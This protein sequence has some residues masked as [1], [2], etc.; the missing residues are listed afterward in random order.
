MALP[1]VRLLHTADVHLGAPEHLFGDSGARIREARRRFIREL[2]QLASREEA[3]GV[4]IAGDLF[5]APEA[6]ATEGKYVA[7]ALRALQRDGR[8]TVLTPGTH[9]RLVDLTRFEHAVVLDQS[10]FSDHKVFETPAGEVHFYGG[11]YDPLETPDDFLLPMRDPKGPGF[12]VAVLHA[13]VADEGER[14]DA[15]DLPATPK[16]L[17]ECGCHYVALGHFHSFREIAHD[18]R[19]VGAYPGTPV[20]RKFRET[21]PRCVALVELSEEAVTVRPVTLPLPWAASQTLDVT[22]LQELSRTEAE[23]LRQLEAEHQGSLALTDLFLELTLRG[24]WESDTDSPDDLAE[25][26]RVRL[27][28]LRLHDETHRL[29]SARIEQ[30]AQQP[31]PEGTF[32]RL[33]RAGQA[34]AP[35]SEKPMYERALIEGLTVIHDVRR[36]KR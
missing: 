3:T 26:L 31:T 19:L 17:A 7:E 18:G 4:V 21:G 27:G 28:G 11:S 35:G 10:D 33:L 6:A 14:F 24:T 23:C 34:E 5:D 1:S 2:P 25:L 29:D 13:A 12:H 36:E 22:G 15:R 8:F 32:V 16:Q 9:D 30:L 20:P